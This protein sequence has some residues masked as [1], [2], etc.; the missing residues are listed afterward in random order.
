MSVTHK[1]DE[2]EIAEFLPVNRG[3]K[4]DP[5]NQAF[6]DATPSGKGSLTFN[7]P[8]GL[9]PGAYYYIDMSPS[10]E[11]T[12]SLNHVTHY[13]ECGEVSLGR[14]WASV[15]RGLVTGFMTM[16]IS[17]METVRLFG[18]P[19]SKWDVT[20]THAEPNDGEYTPG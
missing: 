4:K 13:D 16:T 6:W 14:S 2:T 11:G 8:S 9:D 20:F 1:W 7:G 17:Y 15:E 10:E 19:G 12:W 3:K 5:E 18:E